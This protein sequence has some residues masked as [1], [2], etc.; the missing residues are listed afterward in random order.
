MTFQLKVC[1]N[2]LSG[3]GPGVILAGD[4]VTPQ[5]HEA[6]KFVMNDN[7]MGSE[8]YEARNKVSAFFQ[9]GSENPDG[10]YVFIELWNT[11][12]PEAVAEFERVLNKHVGSKIV[13]DFTEIRIAASTEGVYYYF[14]EI[15]KET[16]CTYSAGSWTT[17][18]YFYPENNEQWWKVYNL[19][20]QMELEIGFPKL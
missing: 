5:V 3:K 7:W 18:L 12:N 11:R 17:P 8:C 20:R 9:S 4:M 10:R 2:Q 6:F 16:G 15:A 19:C 1:D 14:I 13:Q